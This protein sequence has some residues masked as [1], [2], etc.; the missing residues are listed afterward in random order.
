MPPLILVQ[1]M[2]YIYFNP[3]HVVQQAFKKILLQ[4]KKNVFYNVKRKI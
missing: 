2:L 3:Y 4:P 1:A